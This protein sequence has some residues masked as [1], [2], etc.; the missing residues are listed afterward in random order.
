[1]GC[2][3]LGFTFVAIFITEMRGGSGAR[4][5]FVERGLGISSPIPLSVSENSEL[6]LL[7]VGSRV[8]RVKGLRLIH[9]S[10]PL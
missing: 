1:M 8:G 4:W 2:W 5:F 6:L 9:L 3:G 10:A 7:A